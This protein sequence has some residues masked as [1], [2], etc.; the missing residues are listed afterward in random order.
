MRLG[1]ATP[2]PF[3]PSCCRSR[4]RDETSSAR[5]SGSG[6]TAAFAVPILEQLDPNSESVQALVLCPTRELAA[7][8]TIEFEKLAKGRS[9]QILTVVRGDPTRRQLAGPS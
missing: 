9:V 7:Q 6:Q 8:V 1:T 3:R 2:L 5:P 4:Y